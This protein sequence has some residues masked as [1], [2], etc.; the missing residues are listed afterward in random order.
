MYQ[1][2]LQS[3]V[4]FDILPTLLIETARD[5]HP[6]IEQTKLKNDS[7]RVDTSLENAGKACLTLP[8][9]PFNVSECP[10]ATWLKSDS[11]LNLGFWLSNVYM[12]TYYL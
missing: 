6:S 5:S 1:L 2:V 11:S 4:Y 12:L 7:G 8:P 9:C 10:S 3:A